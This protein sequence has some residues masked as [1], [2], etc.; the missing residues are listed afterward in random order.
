M[1]CIEN[2]SNKS[3]CFGWTVAGEISLNDIIFL[4]THS[5]F[6]NN[7]FGFFGDLHHRHG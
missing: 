1:M 5:T 2:V 7:Y 6:E 4:S 3:G